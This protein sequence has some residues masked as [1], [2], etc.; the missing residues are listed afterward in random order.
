MSP[1]I[2][3]LVEAR[4]LVGEGPLWHPEHGALYWTDVNGFLLQRY[5]IASGAVRAWRF[6]EPVCALSLTTDRERLLVALGSRLILWSPETNIRTEF[7]RPEQNTP[8]N[9]LNDGATDPNGA[10]WVGSMRNNV[11]ADGSHVDVEGAT[12][13]LF[14]V[15]PNG[16]VT[17]F[18][19]G[20][21]ITNTVTWSPDLAIFYCGCSVRNVI[22]AYDYDSASSSVTDRRPFLAGHERGV[23]DGSAVDADGYL[24][25]C[26]FFGGCILRVAPDGRVD[27][28]VEM[29]V[30]NVTN[31]AFGGPD[32]RTLYVTTASLHAKGAEPLAGS[33]FALSTE[34]PGLATSRFCL[35]VGADEA[36]R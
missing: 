27:R 18:D 24:W 17:V 34:V 8:F 4:N 25:N 31:C 36:S 32:L 14:R 1:K 16:A 19:T 3:C 11:A 28:V 20:F 7:A 6:D 5:E 10:F 33:L 12:G 30:S 2:T 9:R 22:Y 26:R 29:P 15:A 35:G 13:S 23:P 21:G